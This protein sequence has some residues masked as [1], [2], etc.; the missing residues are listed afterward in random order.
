MGGEGLERLDVE[1]RLHAHTWARLKLCREN[2][3]DLKRAVSDQADVAFA[4]AAERDE[5]KLAYT[6]ERRKRT[7]WTVGLSILAG[8]F[9]VIVGTK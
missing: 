8:S 7:W 9:A 6:V 1:L 2:E 4:R 5:W 3:A